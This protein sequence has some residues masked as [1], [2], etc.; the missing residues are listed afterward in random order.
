MTM[1]NSNL[2]SARKLNFDDHH[3][4]LEHFPVIPR[5]VKQPAGGTE[6]ILAL[7]AAAKEEFDATSKRSVEQ[8]G[9]KY[10]PGEIK[11]LPRIFEKSCDYGGNIR[12]IPDILRGF[13][14]A[15]SASEIDK[16]VR[17]HNPTHHS[18]VVSVDYAFHRS[19]TG[20]RKAK[21]LRKTKNG[22]VGENLVIHQK[23]LEIYDETHAIYEESRAITTFLLI[24]V[25]EKKSNAEKDQ[26][27]KK[28]RAQYPE[29]D[30][31]CELCSTEADLKESL[32]A[33][34]KKLDIKRTSMHQDC[35]NQA[36]LKQLEEERIFIK[37]D[38]D[39]PVVAA[40][41]KFDNKLTVLRVDPKR[42]VY[43]P[44]NALQDQ[45]NKGMDHKDSCREEFLELAY[46]MVHK[47][48]NKNCGG[49]S[50]TVLPLSQKK[51]G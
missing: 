44:D 30:R 8:F 21:I 13:A 40:F 28:L 23:D 39:E 17:H 7:A 51:Y 6:R 2:P 19:V 15:H 38:N 41:R 48:R 1:S 35:I 5:A 16:C 42:N 14:V 9:L 45:L 25:N 34:A 49:N 26:M 4:I 27:L 18:E 20:P 50:A 46:N 36:G 37:I 47:E 12:R 22:V 33:H 32:S 11:S 3:T 43:V 31:I 29:V 24:L 10:I